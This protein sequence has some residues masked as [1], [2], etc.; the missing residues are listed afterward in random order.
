MLLNQAVTPQALL[1]SLTILPVELQGEYKKFV[2][3]NLS[4]FEE[5]GCVTKIF[6]RISLHFT[7]L[8]YHLLEHLVE[9]FGSEQLQEDMSSYREMVEVFLDQTTVL[10]L[11][12]YWPGKRDIPPH[13]DELKAVV[14]DESSTYTL[15]QLG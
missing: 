6:M 15:R 2:A 12:D 9:E 1:L 14:G 3:D 11:M 10:Q 13:F 7:F 4:T 8:D 5:V